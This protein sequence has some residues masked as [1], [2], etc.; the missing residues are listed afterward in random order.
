M[1]NAKPDTDRDQLPFASLVLFLLDVFGI[2]RGI[3][4][5]LDHPEEP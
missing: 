2:A 3:L 4:A 5:F 1:N